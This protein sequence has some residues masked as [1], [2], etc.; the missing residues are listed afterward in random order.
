MIVLETKY[1][2]DPNQKPGGI[3][4][5]KNYLMEVIEIVVMLMVYALFFL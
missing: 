3:L 5:D 2:W 4:G 1:I